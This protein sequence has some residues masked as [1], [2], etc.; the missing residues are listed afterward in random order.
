MAL[1]LKTDDIL[2]DT[3]PTKKT[4]GDGGD[5]LAASKS[6]STGPVTQGA[7]DMAANASGGAIENTIDKE[8]PLGKAAGYDAERVTLGD[9]DTVQGRIAGI[10]DPNSDL[11]KLTKTRA[12]QM[13]NQKGT[14]NSSM[15]VGAANAAMLDK[16][17]EIATTDAQ[18][19]L[20]TKLANQQAGNAAL[21]FNAEQINNAAAKHLQG[22]QDL[23]NIDANIAGESKLQAEKAEIDKMLIG[24]EGEV[25]YELLSRQAEIDKELA[26][27]AVENESRLQAER[28]LID[29]Q[30]IGAQGDI[31]YELQSRKAEIDKELEALRTDHLMLLQDAKG[32]IDLMLQNAAARDAA[33]LQNIRGSIDIQIAELN[34]GATIEAAQLQADA[35]LTR[36]QTQGF[37]DSILQMSD[38]THEENMQQLTGKQQIDQTRL[39]AEF[40]QVIQNSVNAAN[41]MNSH[42]Q[43]INGILNNPE[44]KPAQKQEMINLQNESTRISLSVIADTE[45]INYEEL[46]AGA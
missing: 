43:A 15:A 34:A 23:T 6:A 4:I 18:N 22:K 30:L 10:M 40:N 28:G 5:A 3:G 8:D 36:L 44:L 45:G 38:Q 46:F 27:I 16:A 33:E 26:A 25:Q 13:S 7:S 39:Q 17:T 12:D 31:E 1:N 2:V 37:I 9:E 29:E 42:T 21:G 32:Q 35:A 11:M 24:A 41:V 20:S 19:S 14:L